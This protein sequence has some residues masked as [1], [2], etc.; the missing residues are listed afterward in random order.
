MINLIV[1]LFKIAFFPITIPLAIMKK[2]KNKIIKN[3]ILPS[4]NPLFKKTV[5]DCNSLNTDLVEMTMHRPT[6]SE[7]AKYQG[8]VFS[9]SGKN[10]KYPAL[11]DA[12]RKYGQVHP[13]C[14]HSFY[15]F[16]DGVSKPLYHNNIVKYSNSAFVDDRTGAEKADYES[17]QKRKNDLKRDKNEYN[18]IVKRLYDKAPKSFAGYR[19]MKNSKSD[20]YLKLKKECELLGLKIEDSQ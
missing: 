19:K 1:L 8:R 3:K 17:E 14:R 16:I 15:P 2:K 12:V 5:R 13:D 20:N 6:C 9:I 4:W 11:P 18:E 10:R 7:C